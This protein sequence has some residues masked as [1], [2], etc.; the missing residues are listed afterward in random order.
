MDSEKESWESVLLASIGQDDND[1]DEYS[2]V[3]Q[4]VVSWSR[5]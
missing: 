2:H 1:D 5:I 4:Y 3:T